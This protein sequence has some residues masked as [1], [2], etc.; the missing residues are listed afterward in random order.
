M[1]PS[2]L[3]TSGLKQKQQQEAT[4]RPAHAL[5]TLPPAGLKERQRAASSA[6]APPPSPGGGAAA[7]RASFAPPTERA[8]PRPPVTVPAPAPPAVPPEMF[9]GDS[10][11]DS[12]EEHRIFGEHG[13]GGDFVARP[14]TRCPARVLGPLGPPA[15][16]RPGA[17]AT[18]RRA[19]ATY[20]ARHP[21]AR[22]LVAL[23]HDSVEEP[24][25]EVCANA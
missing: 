18:E 5:S 17:S 22:P 21:R 9:P 14:V 8:T 25:L 15:T 20:A 6:A 2:V 23:A 12:E 13:H 10:G 16:A 4:Q 7:C 1:P 24:V 11:D 3:P 19:T